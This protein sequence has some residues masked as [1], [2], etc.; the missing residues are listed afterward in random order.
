MLRS[1]M[2]RLNSTGRRS[3]PSAIPWVKGDLP[4][5]EVMMGMQIGWYRHFIS[6]SASSH[7][8]PSSGEPQ[9]SE[10]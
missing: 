7:V 9:K 4:I 6:L 10:G 2:S 5:G 1:Q 8:R 3:H